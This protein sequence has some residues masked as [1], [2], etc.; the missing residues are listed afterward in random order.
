MKKTIL[1]SIL[2][3]LL[4][5][6]YGYSIKI[7]PP[8]PFLLTSPDAKFLF[9]SIPKDYSKYREEKSEQKEIRRKYK[10]GGLYKN[11]DSKKPLWVFDKEIREENVVYFDEVSLVLKFSPHNIIDD[12]LIFF[13]LGNKIKSY[14][15]NDLTKDGQYLSKLNHSYD[16]AIV[17]LKESWF[18]EI[19]VEKVLLKIINR[20]NKTLI[21]DIK[22]G[23][24]LSEN[25]SK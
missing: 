9:V 6:T 13:A 4:I 22:T 21:F 20:E 7:M 12:A 10:K 18:K 19:K 25:L 3:L 5:Y 16:A 24:Q 23:N 14:K 2:I 11:D 15:V 17:A 8:R 1:L